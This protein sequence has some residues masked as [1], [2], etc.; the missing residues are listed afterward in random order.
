MEAFSTIGP[1]LLGDPT[2]GSAESHL[3]HLLFRRTCLK[4]YNY[5]LDTYDFETLKMQLAAHGLVRLR[6]VAGAEGTLLVW[7]L[8][9]RG[10]KLLFES[11]TV[12]DP[13]DSAGNGDV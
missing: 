11:R 8:T 2:E 4:G 13:T 1:F 7:S 12:R 5:T 10:T 3:R 9:S 6:R